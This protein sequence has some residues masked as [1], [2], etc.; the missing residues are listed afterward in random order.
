M[1]FGSAG[2]RGADAR[3]TPHR[4]SGAGFAVRC[5]RRDRHFGLTP[6]Q[7]AAGIGAKVCAELDWRV[8]LA[9]PDVEIAVEVDR[10]KCFRVSSDIRAGV[11]WPVRSGGHA[12]VLFS[13]GFE[14][15]GTALR[16]PA[17]HRRAL[18]R[19]DVDLPSLCAGPPADPIPARPAGVRGRRRTRPA[20]MCHEWRRGQVDRRAGAGR[21]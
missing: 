5:R 8:D 15:P 12:L 21:R 6:G 3:R 2:G 9:R 10:G 1:A 19:R 11:V 14:S 17:V 18:H 20:P 13:G 4:N 7:L 16:F